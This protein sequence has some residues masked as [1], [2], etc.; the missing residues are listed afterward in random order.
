MQV[1][2]KNK[3]HYYYFHDTISEIEI[4]QPLSGVRQSDTA[5]TC[6]SLRSVPVGR[7]FR[8]V[9]VHAPPRLTRQLV[10]LGL[11]EDSTGRLLRHTPG[12]GVVIEHQS[13]C[14][15]LKPDQ[16]AGISVEPG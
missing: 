16:A 6:C 9:R 2:I 10:L 1:Y 12:G 5:S 14:L 7:A 13:R 3:N 8:I 4:V 15:C 11:C